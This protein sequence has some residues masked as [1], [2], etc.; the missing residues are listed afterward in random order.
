MAKKNKTKRDEQW[1]EAKRMCRLNAEAVRMAKELGLNPR[2]LIK[3]R[4][5]KAQPWKAPVHVWIREMYDKRQAKAARKRAERGKMQ[6]DNE[7]ESP[8]DGVPAVSTEQQHDVAQRDYDGHIEDHELIPFPQDLAG[9]DLGDDELE[10]FEEDG[11]FNDEPP[12][13]KEIAEQNRFMLRRQKEFRIA[14][15]HIAQSLSDV[16]VVQ[17][18]MLFGSVAVPLKKEVPRFKEYRRAGITVWHECKD[19]DLAVWVDDLSN[20]K[21]LQRARSR[22]L[23]DLFRDQQIGV[24]HHQVDIF[25]LEPGTDRY[26]GVLCCFGRC[27]K[28]KPECLVAGCGA[29][30]FLQQHEDFTFRPDALASE[31]VVVLYDR[32]QELSTELDPNEVPF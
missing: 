6:A 26:L 29:A 30:P 17:R 11:R 4:P 15:D 3:N 13:N 28:G 2:K 31:R 22:S 12:S 23:N 5:N 25:I 14:A 9:N 16:P 7:N 24:A 18:V 21:R 19:V 32:D 20:L 10:D 8:V 1:A 27:P